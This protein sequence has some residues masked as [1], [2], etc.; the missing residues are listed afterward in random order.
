MV[1]PKDYVVIW[2]E[3]A[4]KQLKGIYK[5]IK[6]DSEQAAK[7]VKNKILT[8]TQLLESGKE[9]YKID[10]L[11]LNNSGAYRA[12]IVYSYRIVY[13]INHTT[14]DILRVRYTSREPLEY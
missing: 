8:S 2:S 6:K 4:K 10:E 5:Y 11:K 13:K 14:I 3:V 9:I 12:Y 1:K 7:E